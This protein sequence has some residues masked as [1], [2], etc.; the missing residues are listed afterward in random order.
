MR[1]ALEGTEGVGGLAVV[2][3]VVEGVVSRTLLRLGAIVR[4]KKKSIPTE[5]R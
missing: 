5:R 2:V 3:W 1:E 4:N